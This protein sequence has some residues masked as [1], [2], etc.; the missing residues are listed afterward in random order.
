M[1]T[2][3]SQYKINDQKICTK[4]E[5]IKKIRQTIYSYIFIVGINNNLI[6]IVEYTSNTRLKHYRLV[7]TIIG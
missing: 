6:L 1:T 7:K 2:A 4:Y 3:V 5:Q